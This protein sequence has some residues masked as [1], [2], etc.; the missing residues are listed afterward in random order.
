MCNLSLGFMISNVFKNYP[1]NLNAWV[2]T[3]TRNRVME[4]SKQIGK[5]LPQNIKKH[6]NNLLSTVL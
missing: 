2:G 6:N 5:K 1:K 4:I 3:D